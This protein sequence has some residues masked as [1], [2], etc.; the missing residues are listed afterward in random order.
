MQLACVGQARRFRDDHADIQP[1]L[2]LDPE[3]PAVLPDDAAARSAH[4]ELAAAYHRVVEW[5][6]KRI[7]V[8]V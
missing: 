4:L 5:S 1:I 3:P 8:P 7:A 2:S 6:L